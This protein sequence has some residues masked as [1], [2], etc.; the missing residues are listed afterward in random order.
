[1]VIKGCVCG[2]LRGRFF[3][4]WHRAGSGGF[5][6]SIVLIYFSLSSRLLLVCLGRLRVTT[7]MLTGHR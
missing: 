3:K 4:A 5:V 1:M 7:I 6:L 2:G